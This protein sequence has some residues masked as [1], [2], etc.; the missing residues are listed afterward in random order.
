MQ[1]HNHQFSSAFKT[2]NKQK[3][4]NT[5]YFNIKTIRQIIAH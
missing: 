5:P 4:V 3:Y 1:K 2:P